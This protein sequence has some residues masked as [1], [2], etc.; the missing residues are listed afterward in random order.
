MFV[1][2]GFFL[3]GFCVCVCV[4]FVLFFFEFFFYVFFCC[5]CLFV[6]RFCIASVFSLLMWICFAC[7]CYTVQYVNYIVFSLW[8]K[9]IKV[10]IFTNYWQTFIYSFSEHVD[11]FIYL[12]KF[13]I[14]EPYFYGEVFDKTKLYILRFCT[15]HIVPWF[16]SLR[17][18]F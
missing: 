16:I 18:Y 9:H 14:P 4:C 6:G 2:V 12:I 10:V 17:A 3:W 5:F 1:F 15:H 11:K 7:I 8:R 13:D